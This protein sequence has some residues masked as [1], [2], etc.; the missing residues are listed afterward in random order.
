MADRETNEDTTERGSENSFNAAPR[1]IN[2]ATLVMIVATIMLVIIA[3]LLIGGF[4]SFPTGGANQNT[5]SS[6]NP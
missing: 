6:V 1:P 3:G 4:F 2:K 5:N